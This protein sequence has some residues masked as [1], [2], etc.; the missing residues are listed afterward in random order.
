MG[1][2]WLIVFG[3]FLLS[4]SALSS[5]EHLSVDHPLRRSPKIED[6]FPPVAT[7][8]FL[9]VR[10]PSPIDEEV[11][12]PLDEVVLG[13]NDEAPVQSCRWQRPTAFAVVMLIIGGI[14]GKY[15]F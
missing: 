5:E 10:E 6:G 15:V 3:C 13:E 2:K 4:S 1:Y 12:L 8:A 11:G 14:I 7:Q 9:D